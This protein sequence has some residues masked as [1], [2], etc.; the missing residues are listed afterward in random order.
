MLLSSVGNEGQVVLDMV[1]SVMFVTS[2]V[3]NLIFSQCF[4][5]DSKFLLFS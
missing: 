5:C 2:L 3:D 1:C 4:N